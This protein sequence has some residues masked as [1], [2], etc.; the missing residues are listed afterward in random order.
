MTL[1]ANVSIRAKMSHKKSVC[2]HM[3]LRSEVSICAEMT[4]RGK[5]LPV[6]K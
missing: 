5:M 4:L 1:C 2:A 3:L 6:Q